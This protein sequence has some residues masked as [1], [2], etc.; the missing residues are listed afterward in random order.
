MKK[1]LLAIPAFFIVMLSQAQQLPAFSQFRT[2]NFFYNPA[3]TGVKKHIDARVVY[4]NQWLGYEG[5]PVTQA[6]GF[7]SRLLK[8]LMG[9]GLYACQDAF[10]P[11]SKNIYTG[12]YAFHLKFPDVELSIGMSGSYSQYSTNGSK[13]TI[14]DTHDMAIDRTVTD[15]TSIWDA[16]AGLYLYNDR[17]YISAS[18][19][20]VIGSKLELYSTDTNKIGIFRHNYHAYLGVGYNISQNPDCIWEHSLFAA[21]VPG[22]PFMLDYNLMARIKDQFLAGLSVRFKDALAIHAGYVFS[23]FQIVYSYDL[24]L[25]KIRGSSSGSHEITLAYTRNIKKNKRGENSQFTRQRYQYKF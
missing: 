8:G 9:L 24:L 12:S 11:F 17:F 14:H 23:D 16:G 3:A 5:N 4:R 1:I 20:N 2:N 13:I 7:N 25:S 15:R 19:L 18:M 22:V 6:V 21:M 10:G